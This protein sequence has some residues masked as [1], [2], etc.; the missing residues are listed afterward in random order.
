MYDDLLGPKPKEEK[1]PSH[2]IN[3]AKEK[4]KREY[5]TERAKSAQSAGGQPTTTGPPTPAADNKKDPW[6]DIANDLADADFDA[7]IDPP[8]CD[9]DCNNC[10]DRDLCEDSLAKE[11]DEEEFDLDL[12]KDEEDE[13]F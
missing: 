11:V 3:M 4:E 1:I 12:L 7:D 10:D 13:S 2:R 5:L 6:A 9:L 8:D